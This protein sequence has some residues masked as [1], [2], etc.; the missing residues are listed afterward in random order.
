[1]KKEL[2]FIAL[3]IFLGNQ[4]FAQ[5]A[6]FNHL[7]GPVIIDGI[8]DDAVWSD[9]HITEIIPDKN[10]VDEFPSLTEVSL[11]AFWNDS[12]I[13][14]M[15][16]ATDNFWAPSWIT[17]GNAWQAD[18][19]EIYFDVNEVLEDGLGAGT[20]SPLWLTYNQGHH[21]FAPNWS[22]TEPG[23]AAEYNGTT[24]AGVYDGTDNGTFTAEYK[25]PFE[26][27]LDNT[28][29]ALDPYTRTVIG[30]DICIIDND[31]GA[32]N[33]TNRQRLVWSNDGTVD[34]NFNNMDE[35]GTVTLDATSY[36]AAVPGTVDKLKVYPTI[37]HDYLH[38]PDNTTRIEIY[39][40]LGQR[41][42]LMNTPGTQLDVSSLHT[43][44]HFLRFRN[45]S[46]E[47]TVKFFK[48]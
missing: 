24:W 5:E 2:L 25:V 39:N 11:K 34:E 17:G 15:I 3:S 26:V 6:T 7:E 28:E 8:A 36:V 29:S 13:F 32:D 30:F 18:M 45:G 10:F 27:L 42:M 1:M 9:S 19:L 44:L 21:Q 48:E 43:G 22:E 12:A 23:V 31:D 41:I 14:V 33:P 37:A 16:T 38:L 20:G 35:A 47:K 4:T 40:A 46:I